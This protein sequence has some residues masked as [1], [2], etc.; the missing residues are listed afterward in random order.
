MKLVQNSAAAD[1][2]TDDVLNLLLDEA[3]AALLLVEARAD[4]PGRRIIHGDVPDRDLVSE[5]VSELRLA[6]AELVDAYPSFPHDLESIGERLRNV[7]ANAGADTLESHPQVLDL[8]R[9]SLEIFFRIH[10]DEDAYEAEQRRSNEQG[11]EDAIA[12]VLERYEAYK[13]L[14]ALLKSRVS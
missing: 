10:P 2:L 14:L 12:C 13:Q 6:I 1:N 5:D 7:G 3:E 11:T 9:M 8:V 4:E